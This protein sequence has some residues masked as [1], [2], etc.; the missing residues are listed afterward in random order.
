MNFL[1]HCLFSDPDPAALAGSLWPDFARKPEEHLVSDLFLRHFDRH[2][3]IDRLTDSHELLL[4]LREHLRPT[5]RKTTPL[6]VDMML[7]HH[8]A[9]HWSKYHVQSLSTFSSQTYQALNRFDELDFPE[10]FSRTLY[11]MTEYNWFVS[12]RSEAGILRAI[13]GVARR[14][15]FDNPMADYRHHALDAG[16]AFEMEMDSFIGILQNTFK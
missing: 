12:Y 15:R 13:E 16:K 1:G 6:V 11:W 9:K 7:D 3:Q 14:I 4:P 5:F 8:L 2:Q 10:R